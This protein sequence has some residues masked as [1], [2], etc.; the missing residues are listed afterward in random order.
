MPDFMGIKRISAK[1]GGG[2]G[3]GGPAKEGRFGT[4]I[5]SMG[6]V[7][8]ANYTDVSARAVGRF[9]SAT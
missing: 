6:P 7:T 9:K 1:L 2:G 8:T 3:G 5:G 4:G